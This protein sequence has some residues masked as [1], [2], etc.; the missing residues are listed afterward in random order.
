M[1]LLRCNLCCH[2]FTIIIYNLDVPR[3]T[4]FEALFFFLV[5]LPKKHTTI[6]SDINLLIIHTEP[7]DKFLGMVHAFRQLISIQKD[8]PN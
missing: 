6:L 8:I 5:F 1:K 3:F 4:T 7:L 2:C